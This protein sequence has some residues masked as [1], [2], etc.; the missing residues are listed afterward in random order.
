MKSELKTG[1]AHSVSVVIDASLTV[2]HVS[3]HYAS[4]STMPDVFATAFLVG[5][6]EWACV[7][8][9]KPFYE[10]DEDS[11]GTH[12]S[13]SHEAAT[14]VGDKATAEVSLTAVDGRKLSFSF[15]CKDS[16]GLIS[17]GI[18]ERALISR[19]RFDERLASKINLTK[20]IAAV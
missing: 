13:L 14:P 1:A 4:F 5:F 7:E 8:M 11:V 10:E 18:H 2:P 9:I 16:S 20:T 12:I 19:K 15:A 3:K 6:V 17:R